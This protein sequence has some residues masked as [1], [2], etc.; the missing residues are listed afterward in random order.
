MFLRMSFL[1]YKIFNPLVNGIIL[2]G[3]NNTKYLVLS[4]TLINPY[5]LSNLISNGFV[6]IKVFYDFSS[7]KVLSK[8]KSSILIMS[9]K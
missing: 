9:S 1:T 3:P 8:L 5:T 6:P 7:S 4:K 2:T